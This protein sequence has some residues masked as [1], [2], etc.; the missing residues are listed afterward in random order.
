VEEFNSYSEVSPSN[1]GVKI[2]IKGKM[3][4]IRKKKGEIELFSSGGYFTL[5]G[6]LLGATKQQD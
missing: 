3:P 2:F 4:F 6:G 1:T 5:T